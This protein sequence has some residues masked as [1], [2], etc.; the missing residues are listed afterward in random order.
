MPG[1]DLTADRLAMRTYV[2]QVNCSHF[3]LVVVETHDGEQVGFVCPDCD[4][5]LDLQ[6]RVTYGR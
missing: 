5:G 1:R 6:G 4:A 2:R 3:Q